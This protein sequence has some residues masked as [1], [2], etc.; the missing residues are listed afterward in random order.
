MLLALAAYVVAT[1]II[2]A[3]TKI[4]SAA[5]AVLNAIMSANPIGLIVLAIAALVAAILWV[6]N[7]TEGWGEQWDATLSWMKSLLNLW[8]LGAKMYF[9][10][11]YAGF[12]EMGR[13]DSKG[14][15]LGPE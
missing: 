4:W 7:K 3:A 15:V 14:M 6:V 10:L 11:L 9:L 1:K 2:G 12:M 8:V 13:W 5:Q